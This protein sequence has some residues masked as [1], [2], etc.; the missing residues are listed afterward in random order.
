[1]QQAPQDAKNSKIDAV[2]KNATVQEKPDSLA[3]TYTGQ[4]QALPLQS[5]SNA[6]QYAPNPTDDLIYLRYR[7]DNPQTV[8]INITNATGATVFSGKLNAQST[9]GEYEIDTKGWANGIYI[10]TTVSNGIKLSAEKIVV[11][12]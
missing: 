7:F 8:Q 6:I 1:M 5:Q 2:T 10:A 9:E 3:W 4:G 12:R 11:Q